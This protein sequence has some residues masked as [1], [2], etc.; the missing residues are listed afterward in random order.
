MLLPTKG[1]GADR[2]LITVGS[3]I[4]GI[5]QTSTSVS[6]LWERFN[7]SRSPIR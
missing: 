7:A 5:L 1:I 2:A 4:L 3:V 6:G